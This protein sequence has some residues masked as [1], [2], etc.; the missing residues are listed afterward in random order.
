MC[1]PSPQESQIPLSNKKVIKHPFSLQ[2]LLYIQIYTTVPECLKGFWDRATERQLPRHTDVRPTTCTVSLS[3]PPPVSLPSWLPL[4]FPG[5]VGRHHS[6]QRSHSANSS[7]T[8]LRMLCTSALGGW[9]VSIFCN[10]ATNLFRGQ[11]ATNLMLHC[12]RK[13][14]S[15]ASMVGLNNPCM[16]VHYGSLCLTLHIHISRR[17]DF[18]KWGHVGI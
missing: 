12:V 18:D 9:P 14:Q 17:W 4:V 2:T 8:D 15:A 3:L 5:D 7:S 13:G 16:C 6:V 11:A 1:D 10:A